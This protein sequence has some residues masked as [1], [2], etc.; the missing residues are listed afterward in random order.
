MP[1][2]PHIGRESM[3]GREI[4]SAGRRG[5]RRLH[6]LSLYKKRPMTATASGGR[7]RTDSANAGYLR[8]IR[9]D[10]DRRSDV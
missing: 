1:I 4:S 2:T 6:T 10:N 5:I 9:A 3:K 7:N 8:S